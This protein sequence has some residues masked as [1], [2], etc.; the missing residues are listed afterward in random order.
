MQE[1]MLGLLH[2]CNRFDNQRN[3][4][5]STY[6]TYWVKK[7]ILLAI[8]REYKQTMNSSDLNCNY[9][10]DNKAETAMDAVDIYQLRKENLIHRD[11]PI[12]ENQILNLSYK[13]NKTIKE[14]AMEMNI[15]PEKV[16]QIRAKAIRRMKVLMTQS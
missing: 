15:T 3:I 13:C 5:F 4:R 2:A 10:P 14:I 9:L 6:A 16:R 7:F 1:G 8:S 11:I 12:I